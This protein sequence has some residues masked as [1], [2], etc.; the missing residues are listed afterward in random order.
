MSDGCKLVG[1]KEM[2]DLIADANRINKDEQ[3]ET[4]QKEPISGK[5]RQ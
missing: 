1:T 4:E 2:G 3:N 5:R